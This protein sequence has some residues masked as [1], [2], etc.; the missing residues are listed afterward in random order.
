MNF[1]NLKSK[2]SADY[3]VTGYWSDRAAIEAKKYGNVN[4]VFPK[5][6]KYSSEQNALNNL[7]V[8]CELAS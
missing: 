2:R 7:T 3:V 1:I 8:S 5:L 4:V 6:A